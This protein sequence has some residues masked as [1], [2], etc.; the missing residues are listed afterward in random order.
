M[1]R[2]YLYIC[3]INLIPKNSFAFLKGGKGYAT[4]IVFDQIIVNEIYYPIQIDQH[5]MDNP[6]KVTILS[7]IT[8]C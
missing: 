6:E 4:D 5:Y 3:I 2:L 1:I 8:S 7:P